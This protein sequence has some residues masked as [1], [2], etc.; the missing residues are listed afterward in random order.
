MEKNTDSRK[1]ARLFLFSLALLLLLILGIGLRE[2]G[3]DY[4]SGGTTYDADYDSSDE[5]AYGADYDSSDGTGY[6]GSTGNPGSQSDGQTGETASEIHVLDVGKCNCVLILSGGEAMMV[7]AG[8]N[9]KEDARRIVAYLRGQGVSG[10]RY[11]VLTHPHKDHIRA[12]PE[13]LEEMEVEEVLMGDIPWEV[14]GT[15][16]YRRVWEALETKEVLITNPQQGETY[17]FGTGEFTIL[18]ADRSREATQ[19]N[20]NDCSIGLMWEDGQHRFLFY[21]DGEEEAEQGLLAY[22]K[23][24]PGALR[25]DWMLVAHHGGN[26]STSREML[27]CVQPQFAVI[28]CGEDEDGNRKEPKK[29]VL[30][31]LQE[32]G[33]AVFRTDRDGTVVTLS[34]TEG[35]RVQTAREKQR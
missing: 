10:L 28:T 15:K 20:L 7:D 33:A 12:V 9:E 23:N 2:W 21:G 16:T 14:T 3:A 35:L 29:K 5:T 32:A 18:T 1:R 34:S 30:E 22:E 19:E 31:R 4:D 26:S 17:A 11:L 25:A 13:I 27:E 8:C 24:N 6:G